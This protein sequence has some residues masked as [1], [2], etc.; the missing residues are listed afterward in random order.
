[1]TTHH[2][3]RATFAKNIAIVSLPPLHLLHVTV[4]LSLHIFSHSVFVYLSCRNKCDFSFFDFYYIQTLGNVHCIVVHDKQREE[5]ERSHPS[6]MSHPSFSLLCAFA[7]TRR[8]SQHSWVS[9]KWPCT[10][11]Y[12]KNLRYRR[13]IKSIVNIDMIEKINMIWANERY[14]SL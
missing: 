1:M 11:L 3:N 9:I 2:E 5:K 13:N 12:Q 10:L 14:N 6:S 8:E 4:C 7:K